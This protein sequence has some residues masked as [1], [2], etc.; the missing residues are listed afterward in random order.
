MSVDNLQF[1]Q[2]AGTRRE[3]CLAQKLKTVVTIES[4]SLPK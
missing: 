1:L 4:D 3:V 2:A